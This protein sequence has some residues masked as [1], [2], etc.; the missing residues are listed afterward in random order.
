MYLQHLFYILI[1]IIFTEAEKNIS[2]QNYTIHT[3]K[4]EEF[5]QAQ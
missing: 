3:S 4:Y 5:E 2:I 1:S